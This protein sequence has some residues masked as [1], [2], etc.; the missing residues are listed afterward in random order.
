MK[1]LLLT[2][3]LAVMSS[4]AMAEWIA[5]HQDEEISTY[6]NPATMRKSGNKVKMWVLFDQK[7]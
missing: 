3:I 7:R 5:I 2:L 4:S 1:K 6:A